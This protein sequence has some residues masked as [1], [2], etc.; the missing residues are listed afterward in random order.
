MDHA[1]IPDIDSPL[2]DAVAPCSVPGAS[3]DSVLV[4]EATALCV[5]FKHLVTH[6]D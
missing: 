1:G 3:I 2:C 6:G 4:V 5:D